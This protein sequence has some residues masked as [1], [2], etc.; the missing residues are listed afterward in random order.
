MD[1]PE[2]FLP[3][4]DDAQSPI[5]SGVAPRV[6]SDAAF[7]Y[8]GRALTL[9][10]FASY[11]ASYSFGPI[12]PDFIV[13]HHTAVPSASWARYP[14]GLVWDANEGG[15]NEAQIKAKRLRQL[16][17]IMRYYRDSKGWTAGPHLFIDDRWIYLFTPMNMV[18]IHAAQGNGWRDRTGLHYSVGIEIV[19]YYEHTRWP[20]PIATLVRGAVRALL[21]RL[22]KIRAEYVRG[23]GGIC[24]HRDWNK[25][26]CPGAAITAAYYLDV[27]RGAAPQLGRYRVKAGVS[28]GASVRSGPSRARPV[29]DHLVAGERWTGSAVPGQ[30]VTLASFGSGDVWICNAQGH[31]VWANLLEADRD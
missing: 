13:L 26:A 5:K 11:V 8:V 3:F 10:E 6:L 24:S 19:G 16:D 27:I 28:A 4:D 1:D 18:G 25:P 9:A 31:C 2:R 7:A 23:P 17:S 12:P 22:P 29:V 21:G 20:T 14:S 30:S 15:L